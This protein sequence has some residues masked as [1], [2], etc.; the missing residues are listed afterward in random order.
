MSPQ[1]IVTVPARRFMRLV[2]LPQVQA[3]FGMLLIL[4]SFVVA[5]L[6]KQSYE[7]SR[8]TKRAAK[9][10]C[11]R[12]QRLAPPLLDFYESFHDTP[13]RVPEWALREYRQTVPK[14]C[15]R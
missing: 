14:T 6:A 2:T 4:V 3:A 5:Y 7:D 15:P 13:H 8:D 12:A 11:L 1:R 10:S 9:Q